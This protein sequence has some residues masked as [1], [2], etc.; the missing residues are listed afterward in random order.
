MPVSAYARSRSVLAL[1][2]KNLSILIQPIHALVTHLNG[3]LAAIPTTSPSSQSFNT[4]IE[5]AHPYLP[6]TVSSWDVD[7]PTNC[8]WI[9]LVFDKR[10]AT[11]NK[12]NAFAVYA[13]DSSTP[14]VEFYGPA[15]SSTWPSAP[16]TLPGNSFR[17]ALQVRS[18]CFSDCSSVVCNYVAMWTNRAGACAR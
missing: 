16:V 17:F 6:A 12:A 1:S 5:S 14:I 2:L 8:N 9:T 7:F 15:A 13:P 4:V 11:P 3:V 18:V 10:C